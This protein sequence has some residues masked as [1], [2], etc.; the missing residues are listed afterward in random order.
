MGNGKW[1]LMSRALQLGLQ[2]AYSLEACWTLS[3]WLLY[4]AHARAEG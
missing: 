4:L 3:C 2:T 1:D